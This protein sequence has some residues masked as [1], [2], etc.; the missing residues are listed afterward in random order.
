MIGVVPLI[1]W[2]QQLTEHIRQTLFDESLVVLW[3]QC[4]CCHNLEHQHQQLLW[5][6]SGILKPAI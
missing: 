5:R 3:F 2:Q 4:K 1:R 6:E